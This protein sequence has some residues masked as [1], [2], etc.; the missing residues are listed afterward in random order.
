MP[1]TVSRVE[2]KARGW[3]GFGGS[4]GYDAVRTAGP[5]KLRL[6]SVRH[7]GS[8]SMIANSAAKS[9]TVE[10]QSGA[11][12]FDYTENSFGAFRVVGHLQLKEPI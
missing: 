8:T 4:E 5:E 1:Q 12:G 2:E 7:A 11:N 9:G 10:R 3:C 6:P